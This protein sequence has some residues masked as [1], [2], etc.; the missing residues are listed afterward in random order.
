MAG[1]RI[2][3][4]PA[5]QVLARFTNGLGALG[6]Y[7]ARQVM[8]RA[9]N[10]AGMPTLTKVRRS[11][12]DATSAPMKLIRTQVVPGKAFSGSAVEQGGSFG[13]KLEFR[14]VASG[15]PLPLSVFNPVAFKGGVRAKVWGAYHRYP[16]MFM[17]GGHWPDRVPFGR[18]EMGGQVF[19]RQFKDRLPIERSFG[20]WLPKELVKPKVV[21][22]FNSGLARLGDDIA[23]ELDRELTR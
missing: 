11:V 18:A 4:K 9:L 10:R 20:P 6:D 15:R 17:T 7:R 5:D 13:E 1:D 21:E 2:T 8:A 12:R 3:L 14:I 16:R 22:A 23:H 19:H